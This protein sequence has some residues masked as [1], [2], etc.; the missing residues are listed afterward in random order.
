MDRGAWQATVHG[1]AKSDMTE[2]LTHIPSVHEILQAR[3]M[4]W[5]S[6]RGSSQLRDWTQISHIV[7]GFLTVWAT[8]E[9]HQCHSEQEKTETLTEEAKEI[10]W[11]PVNGY[12]ELWASQVK[13][14]VKNLP[15]NAVDRCKRSGLDSWIGKNPWRRIP[16]PTPLFLPRESPWLWSL[17]GHS[18]L[19]CTELDMTE[20]PLQA[21]ILSSILEWQETSG[22]VGEAQIKCV[23]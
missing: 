16:Q 22:K 15:A 10:G 11:L 5:I 2:Q 21:C 6:S 13:R 23:I 3:I 9:A 20:E 18:P 14:V 7:G 1:V 12:P 17:A 8:W 19:G 4:E